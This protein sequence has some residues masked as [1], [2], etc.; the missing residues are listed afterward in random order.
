M[1]INR[2]HAL[3]AIAVAALMVTAAVGVPLTAD[4]EQEPQPVSE[5]TEFAITMTTVIVAAIATGAIGG[6]VG[7]LLG[8]YLGK[9]SSDPPDTASPF[10]REVAMDST[11]NSVTVLASTVAELVK[12]NN[13]TWS[14]AQT[15]LNRVAEIASA[16]LWSEGASYDPSRVLEYASV[17]DLLGNGLYNVS[18]AMSYG[19]R[20]L[21]PVSEWKG[22]DWSNPIQASIVWEGGSTA[23][24]TETLELVMA[25]VV[26]AGDTSHN[27]VYISADES[28]DSAI[29]SKNGGEIRYAASGALAAS[30]GP[31]K[32]TVSLEPGYYTLSAGTWAGQFLPVYSAT[33]DYC[34]DV[35]G[36]AVIV[37]DDGF[38]FVTVD[39][40]GSL[41]IDYGGQQYGSQY[42]R[43][44]FAADGKTFE[45]SPGEGNPDPVTYAVQEYAGQ[46]DVFADCVYKA[47][48]AGQTMWMISANAG[49]AN[50]LLSP[51][52]VSP[53]LV[54]I[55]IDA[56]QSYAMYVSALSQMSAYYGAYGE[57]LEA[58]EVKISSE[59]LDLYCHGSIYDADG[60]EIASDV[61]FTPYVYVSNMAVTS[62][63]NTFSQDGVIMIWDWGTG[64]LSGWDAYDAESHN[65]VVM[66]KGASFV[67]D[68]IVYHGEAAQSVQLT[69]K[70]IQ[71]TEG[72]QDII[73][74]SIEDPESAGD[75]SV[76]AVLIM[77]ELATIFAIAG[78]AFRVPALYILAAVSAAVGLLA[79]DWVL[80]LLV[81]VLV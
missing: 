16:T 4:E 57:Q 78:C 34:A 6:T 51:S 40:D 36:G 14:L 29:W 19:F 32:S 7:S 33:E 18:E 55:G 15:Y 9:N 24:A 59:S 77:V 39:A 43:Y 20:N 53:D 65:V 41:T 48:V 70:E 76:L 58:G 42:L 49:E 28:R 63:T 3:L 30:V 38:G 31:G 17:Y 44:R 27:R 80:D 79:G 69:V 5:P 68:E 56:N 26:E 67:A 81:G 2:T 52:S 25:S 73:R 11:A 74:N 66:P 54:G 50:I 22:K 21:V 62:G 10:G 1:N 23:A 60:V 64:G 75:W 46:M 45:T 35:D 8:Y 37:C 12:S 47:A 61:V 72:L 13:Q 71:R